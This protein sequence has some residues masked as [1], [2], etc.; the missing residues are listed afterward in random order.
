[1]KRTATA[2][3][4]CIAIAKPGWAQTPATINDLSAPTSPAFVLLGVSPAAVERPENPKVFII[5]AL[6][7][8]SSGDAGFPKDFALEVAPYWMRSHSNLTFGEYQSPSIGQSIMQ[9][10]SISIGTAPIP[11]AAKTSDPLGTKL[12]IGFTT[13]LWNGRPNPYLETKIADLEAASDVALDLLAEQAQ[14]PKDEVTARLT[15]QA[16]IDAARAKTT[17]QALE[18][19]AL[20]AQ[21]IGFFLTVSGGQTWDFFADEVGNAAARRRGV[22]VTPAYRLRAC[23]KVEKTTKCESSFDGIAVFRVLKET[24]QDASVDLGF[25]TAWRATREF[26]LSFEALH[27]NAPAKTSAV[28]M[29]STEDS[30]RFAG[31]VEYR[32]KDDLVVYGSFGQDFKKATGAKPLITMMGL[33]I[34][35][36]SKPVVLAETK[37]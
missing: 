4:L 10:V 28:S 26:G 31:L 14:L 18:I 9:T 27:R 33:N 21:R 32:I 3:L 25:K 2:F 29:D 37:K 36:G 15:L 23:G 6:N 34:G 7:R 16:K 30:N 11:G 20:D 35:F 22:W 12:A 1:M 13:R 8:M 5:N 17:V 19:Q 24:D